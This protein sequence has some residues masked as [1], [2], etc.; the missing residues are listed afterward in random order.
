MPEGRG[1]E[2]ELAS[3]FEPVLLR[4]RL[5]R[6]V[7]P[8]DVEARGGMSAAEIGD[9]MHAFGFPPPGA[10]EPTFTPAEAEAFVEL[11]KL[12]KVWPQALTIQLARLYGRT[13][14][15]V[16]DAE[17]QAFRRYSLPAVEGEDG[18][19]AAMLERV[20]AAFERLLP[21]ADPLLV[22]VHRRWVEHEL[23]QT[24]AF[25]AEIDE[26][27]ARVPGALEV[28]FLFCDL[29]DFTHY[30]ALH[31]DAAAIAVIDQFFDV[32]T[33][34][35]G[36]RGRLVKS[37]GDG[38]MLVYDQPADAVAAGSRVIDAVRGRDIPG[39]HASVHHGVAIA[40]EGDYFGSAVNL[41]ARLLA[42]A[43]RDELV[44]TRPVVERADEFSWE[45]IGERTVRGVESLV[46]VF[47]LR[48]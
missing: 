26:D 29:K 10:E 2:E 6:T 31:G 8:A 21:I 14:G 15:R 32:V 19:R 17:L 11:G 47:R 38:A 24:A 16:A 41:A 22:G 33:S 37:L 40:R 27:V 5:E 3:I 23:G 18:D 12:R 35:R 4:T 25:Q 28:S 36:D 1:R 45:P 20:Q 13:L 43:A 42:V 48:D 39:V 46:E 9:V 30:A 7:T 34:A 44:A